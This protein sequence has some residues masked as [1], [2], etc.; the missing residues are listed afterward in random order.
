VAGVEKRPRSSARKPEEKPEKPEKPEEKPDQKLDESVRP[1]R[2]ARATKPASTA[3]GGKPAKSGSA[4][5]AGKATGGRKRRAGGSGESSRAAGRQCSPEAQSPSAS[6]PGASSSRL[7]DARARMY[8]DLV[9]ESAEYLFGAKGYEH[10]T[11]HEVASEAGIS[12]KT[13]YATFSGKRE[14]YDEIQRVRGG[15]FVE[16]VAEAT[17]EGSDALDRVRRLVGAYVDFVLGHE[18]WLRIH[19]QERLNWALGPREGGSAEFWQRGID[20]LTE[21]LQRGVDEAAF[22]E[23]DPRTMAMMALSVMQVQVAQN[24]A[25]AARSRDEMVAEITLQLERLLCPPPG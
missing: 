11:M 6:P 22:Y 12:L 5:K 21:L 14:L 24:L 18:D 23:G 4:G 8:R 19:L 15:A 3:S 2:P 16:Q 10:A 25:G 20:T 1:V 7:E 9:F 17:R 13:V